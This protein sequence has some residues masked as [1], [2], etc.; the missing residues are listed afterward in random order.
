[1]QS[2]NKLE[3][4]LNLDQ[5]MVVYGLRALFHVSRK[6]KCSIE[7][8]GF[9]A[10]LV[11]GPQVLRELPRVFTDFSWGFIPIDRIRRVEKTYSIA[12]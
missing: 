10:F 1:M 11:L 9:I 12:S 7:F 6:R 5:P 3:M 8:V 2:N 4:V